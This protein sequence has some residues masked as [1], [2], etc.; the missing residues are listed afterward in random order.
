M[1]HLY[2]WPGLAPFGINPEKL[3]EMGAQESDSQYHMK[4][5]HKQAEKIVAPK[6][7]DIPPRIQSLIEN[8]Y[9]WFYQYYYQGKR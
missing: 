7:H 1:T 2:A 5:T 9:A 3:G 4:Y 8:A 6:R